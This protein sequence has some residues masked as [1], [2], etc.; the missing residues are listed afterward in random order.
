[1]CQ[2][3]KNSSAEICI[4]NREIVWTILGFFFKETI[5]LMKTEWIKI[6]VILVEDI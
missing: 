5:M 6:L 1:M 2:F 4:I 3:E